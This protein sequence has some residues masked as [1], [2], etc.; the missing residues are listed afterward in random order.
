MQRVQ[1]NRES[2]QAYKSHS[3]VKF[4][5]TLFM[6]RYLD[7]APAEKIL[8]AKAI[9]TEL[10]GCRERIRFLNQSKVQYHWAKFGAKLIPLPS[11]R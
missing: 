2:M 5:E 6:D 7:D 4:G 1:F 10:K 3:Y 8:S 11:V 9:R